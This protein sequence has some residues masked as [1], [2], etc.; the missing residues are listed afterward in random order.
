[1]SRFLLLP[2]LFVLHMLNAENASTRIPALILA[3]SLPPAINCPGNIS[4]TLTAGDCDTIVNYTVVAY[5]NEPGFVLSQVGGLVSGSP[6]SIGEIIN[7]FLVTDVAGNTAACSFTV[8]VYNFPHLL[9]CEENQIIALDA[10]CTAMAAWDVLLENLQTG[11]PE[12]YVV[13]LD[14]T[15]PFGNG[16]WVPASLSL[17][18]KD[19]TYAYRLRNLDNADACFG[20]ISVKDQQGPKMICEDVTVPCEVTPVTPQFLFNSLGIGIG[21]PQISDNCGVVTDTNSLSTLQFVDVFDPLTQVLKYTRRIWSA[22]D[23]SGNKSSCEQYIYQVKTNLAEVFFPADVTFECSDTLLFGPAFAGQ[24]YIEFAQHIFPLNACAIVNTH[25]DSFG[26]LCGQSRQV[27]RSWYLLD[28]ETAQERSGIQLIDIQDVLPPQVACPGQLTISVE[29]SSCLGTVSFPDAVITDGCSHITSFLARWM[30]GDTIRTQTGTLEGFTGSDPLIND[31]LGLL[32]AVSAFPIGTRQ[33]TYVATDACGNTGSCQWTLTVLDFDVP[34]AICDTLKQVILGPDGQLTLP[35]ATL[36]S[37][38]GDACS[39]V[40]FKTR[41]NTPGACQ[42]AL[43]WDDN[44]LLCCADLG[45]TLTA[46]LRVYD[47]TVPP[48]EVSNIFGAGHF[49]ECTAR[50]VVTDTLPP[51]CDNLPDLTVS[52]GVFDPTFAAY[53][54]FPFSC[55]VDSSFIQLD[56]SL[57]DTLCR[58]GTITR[59]FNIVNAFGQTSYCLQQITVDPEEQHYYVRFPD[60]FNLTACTEGSNYGMPAVFQLPGSCERIDISF[61]DIIDTTVTGAC[62]GI[63]RTWVIRNL[64]H[65]NQSL[66]L[67]MVPNPQV[68]TGPVVSAPGTTGIWAPTALFENFWSANTNGYQY[69]QHI[70]VSD[71]LAP[72]IKSCPVTEQVFQDSSNNNTQIWN[73]TYWQDTQHQTSDLCEGA[74]DLGITANDACSGGELSFRYWL[75]LDLDGD[76]IQETVVNSDNLP[77]FNSIRYNNS[78]TPNFG[79]GTLRQFDERAVPAS[80]KWGF[81]LQVVQSDT[82]ATAY[83]RFNS[84]QSP[85]VYGQP[86]L[87]YGKHRIQW[88]VTD[89][90]GNATTCFYNFTIRDGKA[91]DITCPTDFTVSFEEADPGVATLQLADVLWSAADNCSPANQIAT[92]L[93]LSGGGAGFPG[94]PVQHLDFTCLADADSNRMVEVW[95]KDVAG[96][97]RFCAVNVH[98]DSCDLEVPAQPNHLVGTVKLETGLGIKDVAIQAFLTK[99][100][101]SLILPDTTDTNGAYDIFIDPVAIGSTFIGGTAAIIP[102]KNT[103]PLEGVTTFDL[104]LI[105][106]HI[107]GLDTLDSPYKII[108]ADANKSGIV[109]SF[110]VVELRKLILGIYDSLPDNTTWRFVPADYVFPDSINPFVPAF[111]ESDSTY[112][113]L[114]GGKFDFIGLKVG[115]VNVSVD[116]QMLDADIPERRER[117]LPVQTSQRSV[118][119]GE[120]FTATFSTL[121][122]SQGFQFTLHYKDLELLE[123]NPV[124]GMI[125]D[126]F[127]HFPEKN[128]LTVACENTEPG[129]FSLRFRAVRSGELCD[130]LRIGSDITPAAAWLPVAKKQVVPASVALRFVDTPGFALLQ[131]QPNPFADKTV[132]RFQLPRASEATLQVFDS[133]GKMVFTQSGAYEQGMHSVQVDLSNVQPG[134]LYY[135]L[136]TPEHRAVEK[137]VK[138]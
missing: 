21:Y 67:V 86:Q 90:C 34:L 33:I 63:E 97:A 9:Q 56:Y 108:A 26:L 88:T 2:L 74:L 92:A 52:C 40:F 96:N 98:V 4:F 102:Y 128:V 37:G 17:A 103:S 61:N 95:V 99:D 126:Q 20:N 77:G 115:D 53:G 125:P 133:N 131:N 89:P 22:T 135:Q 60:D 123:I 7:S 124:Q 8:T 69:T 113:F 19:K 5:D 55:S 104:L 79:G 48:G 44:V 65:Y 106:K 82:Q 59:T 70:K 109:T 120:E 110:D 16:P 129:T 62:F 30:Q 1:M 134:V 29:T 64:C 28:S 72:V 6:F 71:Q 118:L 66:P 24:P 68:L 111:P 12:N 93:R 11:C 15:L 46:I 112:Y 137:M 41:L 116:P 39:P 32:A 105:S 78:N 119:D 47:V 91:P 38:S 49:A 132:I 31:T 25:V 121:L 87:P 107:I 58:V 54:D 50:I 3:D 81:A 35:A 85:Q 130:L 76:N 101:A 57:F 84:A 14:K 10:A 83:V 136:E 114:N 122:P 18:D 23:D 13:E 138:L 42:S 27:F 127:A 51:L 94:N 75:F 36:D 80:Q 117:V 100:T 45:D 73:E 43:E